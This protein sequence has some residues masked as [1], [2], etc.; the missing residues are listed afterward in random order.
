MLL[1]LSGVLL[2][3]SAATAADVG[4]SISIGQPG[5][6]GQ[7]DIGDFPRPALLYPR[8]VIIEHVRPGYVAEPI[9]LRVPPG[10]ARN[11]SR[12]CGRYS[13]CGRPVYF[14]QDSWYNNVYAP[15][16]RERYER[17]DHDRDRWSDYD[18]GR[19]EHDNRGRDKRDR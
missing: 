7:L 12:Y 6:Y 19:G 17:V 15:R 2:F 13:A 18:R 5:F 4:V 1:V 9:Y 10:Y 14:V 8:P 16:Y 11:W 3:G